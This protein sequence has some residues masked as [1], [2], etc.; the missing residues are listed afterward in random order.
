M[1]RH[2]CFVGLPQIAPAPQLYGIGIVVSITERDYISVWT[3]SVSPQNNGCF[4]VPSNF[5]ISLK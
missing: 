4:H 2:A 1:A 5:L 3:R